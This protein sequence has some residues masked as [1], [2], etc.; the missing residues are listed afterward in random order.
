LGGDELV[1]EV[2]SMCSHVRTSEGQTAAQIADARG[3]AKTAQL[4]EEWPLITSLGDD[5]QDC[6]VWETG[7][8]K[9][10]N[11][12]SPSMTKVVWQME[13]LSD[14][15]LKPSYA[16]WVHKMWLGNLL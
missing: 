13:W 9:A 7:D 5:G 16:K 12:G 8:S 1:D 2:R 11:A 3:F 4:L 15:R 6:E 10:G 14:W